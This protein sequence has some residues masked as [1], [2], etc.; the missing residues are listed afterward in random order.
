MQVETEIGRII[1]SETGKSCSGLELYLLGAGVDWGLAG[2]ICVLQN[3]L[4]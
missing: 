4:A 2:K 1:R 3:P